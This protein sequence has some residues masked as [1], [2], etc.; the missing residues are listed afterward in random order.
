LGTVRHGNRNYSKWLI[1]NSL[2]YCERQLGEGRQGKGEGGNEMAG[3]KFLPAGRGWGLPGLGG[4]GEGG[5]G[6]RVCRGRD[7]C[8]GIARLWR[9]QC[10]LVL[11]L[12]PRAVQLVP[13]GPHADSQQFGR[14]GPVVIGGGQCVLDEDPLGLGHVE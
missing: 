10:Q 2:G 9:P 1:N 12:A 11:V 3:R 5:R 4:W 7:E 13:E 14:L 8:A 6:C